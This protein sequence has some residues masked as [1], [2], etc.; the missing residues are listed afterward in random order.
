MRWLRSGFG[1]VGSEEKAWEAFCGAVFVQHRRR[2]SSIIIISTFYELKMCT[3]TNS[4]LSI[5]FTSTPLGGRRSTLSRVSAIKNQPNAKRPFPNG[6]Q[7][8]SS[9]H[10]HMYY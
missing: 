1:S 10:S 3:D 7:S 5:L 9:T 4:E 6:L 8:I 2:L